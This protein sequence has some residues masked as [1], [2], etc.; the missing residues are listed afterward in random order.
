[1]SQTII[2]KVIDQAVRNLASAGC[3]FAVITPDGRKLGEL[4]VDQPKKRRRVNSFGETGYQAR[5]LEMNIG[6][7]AVF[8]PEGHDIEA[9]RKVIIAHAGYCFGPGNATSHIN[10][11]KI[12]LLRLA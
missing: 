5:I 11:D 4:N 1:M 8:D 3:Q 12:E 6:D 7:V 10:G 2:E 9:F